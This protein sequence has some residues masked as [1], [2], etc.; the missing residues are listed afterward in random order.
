MSVLC[1]NYSGTGGVHTGMDREG[2]SIHWV[3]S[4]HDLAL[5]IHKNQIRSANLPEVHAER[6]D[7]K[8]IEF[9]GIAGGDMSRDAFIEPKTREKPEGSGEHSFASWRLFSSVGAHRRDRALRSDYLA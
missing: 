9:F 4:L 2:R 1:G 5:M 3:F 7:P 8:M 6:V